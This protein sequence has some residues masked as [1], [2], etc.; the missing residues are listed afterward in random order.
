[1]RGFA[2]G[3][4]TWYANPLEIDSNRDGVSDT[5][6]FDNDGNGSP[7]DTDGD[8]IPDLFDFDNDNDGVPD[9]K[10]LAPFAFTGAGANTPFSEAAPLKLTVKNVAAGKPTFVD[11]QL[12]PTDPKRLWYAFNVLDWPSD[13]EAQMQDIDGVTF[14]DT[15]GKAANDANGDLKLIPMLEIRINAPGGLPTTNLPSQADLT[16]YNITVNNFND[17]Y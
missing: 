6:E 15:G 17:C 16:P 7:D 9:N 2:L 14:A 3:G 8:N 11:F 13:S 12:R 4:Q 1:M 10:D 5:V